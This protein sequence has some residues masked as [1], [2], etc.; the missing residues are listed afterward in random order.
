MKKK[1]NFLEWNNDIFLSSIKKI[2]SNIFLIIILD[3]LFYFLSGYLVIFWLGRIQSRIVAF[4]LPSDIASLG[5]DRAQLL[6]KDVKAFYYLVVISFILVL[7]AI[8]FLASILKG[9][10]WARTTKTKISFHLISKFLGLN[11]IWMGFW[12]VIVFL[13]SYLVEPASTPIFMI[14]AIALSLYF[15]NTLYAIFMKENKIRNIFDSIKLG[16]A[17]IHLFLLPYAVISLLLY[18][19][20]KLGN[21][22]Q[23]NYSQIALG[24]IVVIYAAVV[25]YYVS[26]LVFEIKK[27]KA[28]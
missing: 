24:A 3:A 9:I 7:I 27:L 8:I 2:D 17:K 11:L 4:N 26:E 16:I 10:I 21:L 14:V 15:T 23:F 18:I 1:K 19:L 6:V 12:F 22:L 13:I 25:R 20:I 28:I 5:Y